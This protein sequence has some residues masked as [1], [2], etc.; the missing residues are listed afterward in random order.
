MC[1]KKELVQRRLIDKLEETVLHIVKHLQLCMNH[2]KKYIRQDQ[3]IMNEID[4]NLTLE[5]IGRQ[6]TAFSIGLNYHARCHTDVNVFYTL[7]T[8]I[9]PKD[10]CADKVIYYFIF[11]TLGIRILLRSGD[12]FMF[13]PILPHSCLNPQYPGCHIMSAYVFRKPFLEVT[14]YNNIKRNY[15]VVSQDSTGI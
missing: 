14:L 6:A 8:V 5:A 4:N 12:L 9:A 11:P 1:T 3:D 10:V 13:N 15:M 7:A 2:I